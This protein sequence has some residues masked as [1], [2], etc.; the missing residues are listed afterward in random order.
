MVDVKDAPKAK[1][2][3]GHGQP[4][5]VER[6][7]Q[8]AAPRSAAPMSPFGF[9]RRFA[10]EMDNL[11]EDFG[12]ESGRH[13]P[14]F[15]TRGHEL[16]RRGTGLVSAEWSPRIDILERDGRI[17]VRADLPG[18]SKDD[19]HVDIADQVLTLKGERRCEK[20]EEREGYRYRE[21]SHGSFFRAVPLPDGIDASKASAEF[22]NGVLEVSMPAPSNWQK[23]ARRIE[24][25]DGK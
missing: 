10:E 15:F 13:M 12:L 6:F 19:I 20:K 22:R 7:E 21:C 23:K 1:V 14:S 8:P 18:M 11:F 3:N 5:E 24:I 4:A 25:R 2:E 9:M 16:L 17:V